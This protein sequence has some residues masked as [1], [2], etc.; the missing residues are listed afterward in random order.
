[1]TSSNNQDAPATVTSDT[2]L[3]GTLS[4]EL[5]HAVRLA[6][7]KSLQPIFIQLCAMGAISIIA[8]VVL[9]KPVNLKKVKMMG[10]AGH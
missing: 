1:M 10:F 9:I 2:T 4:T 5:A 3:I 6:Y 7:I 8:A